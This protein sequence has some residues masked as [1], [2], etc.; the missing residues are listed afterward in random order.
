MT[1]L[2]RNSRVSETPEGFDTSLADA[3]TSAG[4]YAGDASATARTKSMGSAK[5]STTDKAKDTMQ[6]VK[7]NT[8][9]VI[10]TASSKASELG[11]RATQSADAG[12]E[13]AAS[14][15][16]TLAGTLRERGQSMGE[17]QFQSAAMTAADK[18][19]TGADKLRQTDMD[20]L[21]AQL[22][23]MVRQRPVESLLIAAA[24]G[25]LFSK[26]LR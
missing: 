8:D 11:D 10:G 4:A 2:E 19:E 16:D 22:E 7:E 23:D 21:I 5:G 1:S 6:S 18:L 26:A 25:Y 15:M 17:G 3:D 24:A 12:M 14:G 20:Q 9:Q 13:K